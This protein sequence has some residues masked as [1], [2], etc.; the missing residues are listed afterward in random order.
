MFELTWGIPLIV[1][2]IIYTSVYL[3]SPSDHPETHQQIDWPLIL[4]CSII[5]FMWEKSVE[6][7]LW[8]NVAILLCGYYLFTRLFDEEKVWITDKM[9]SNQ[10]RLKRI[11][12]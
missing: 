3:Q 11:S 5:I 8:I 4:V 2:G 10:P 7:A 6:K 1:M 12:H 9:K